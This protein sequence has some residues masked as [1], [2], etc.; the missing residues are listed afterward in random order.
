MGIRVSVWLCKGSDYLS[1]MHQQEYSSNIRGIT[2]WGTGRLCAVKNIVYF[3]SV[4]VVTLDE[5]LCL[6]CVSVCL[7]VQG[8]VC[9]YARAHAYAHIC[10][11]QWL[12]WRG[13]WFYPTLE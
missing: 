3:H 5:S 2:G 7:C 13:V 1:L 4:K 10:L 9:V 8:C 6:T 12:D 11:S